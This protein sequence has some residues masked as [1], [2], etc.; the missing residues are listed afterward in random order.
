M[1]KISNGRSIGRMSCWELMMLKKKMR[2]E[3]GILLMA[4]NQSIKT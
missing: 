2:N 3:N 4:Q 1:R